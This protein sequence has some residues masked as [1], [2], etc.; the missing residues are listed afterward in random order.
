MGRQKN[1]IVSHFPK[2][3]AIVPGI[4]NGYIACRLSVDVKREYRQKK[5]GEK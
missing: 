2:Y 3:I 5:D 1:T 4:N